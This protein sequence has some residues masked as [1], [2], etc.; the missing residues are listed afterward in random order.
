MLPANKFIRTHKSYIVAI[1]KINAIIGNSIEIGEELIPIGKSYK[2]K[3]MGILT[4]S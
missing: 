4:Q 2:E 1:E 3:V